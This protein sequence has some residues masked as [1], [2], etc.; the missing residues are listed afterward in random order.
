MSSKDFLKDFKPL[1]ELS[2]VQKEFLIEHYRRCEAFWRHWTATIWSLPSVASAINIGVYTL[3]FSVGKDI[4]DSLQVLILIVLVLLNTALT[5]GIWKHR[6]MQQEFGK[7][8]LD[9]EEYSGIQIIEFSTI[10]RKISGSL[11][12]VIVMLLISLISFGLL[13]CE[14]ICG[15]P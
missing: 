4:K 11:A 8:I 12:Y 9:I 2:A 1:N 3:L 7:R 14:I 10:Q 5:I 13:F 15:C 6:Y